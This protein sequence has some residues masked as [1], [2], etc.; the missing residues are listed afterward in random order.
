LL[1]A[2]AIYLFTYLFIH[3]LIYMNGFQDEAESLV[4]ASSW[5]F[6]SCLSVVH[7]FATFEIE[8]AC[9]SLVIGIN[10]VCYFHDTKGLNLCQL[11]GTSFLLFFCP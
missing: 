10:Q 1:N 8:A 5:L 6:H 9:Q 2:I 3:S 11:Y 4:R 7:A